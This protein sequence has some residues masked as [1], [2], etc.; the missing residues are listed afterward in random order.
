MRPWI[1]APLLALAASA[2]A[3]TVEVTPFAGYRLGGS[4]SVVDDG[5]RL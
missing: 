5:N 2:A 3:Q 4:F 1:L